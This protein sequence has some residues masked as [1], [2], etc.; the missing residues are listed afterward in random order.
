MLVSE[1]RI[2]RP[3][4]PPR[5]TSPVRPRR[6]GASNLAL[7]E[8]MD[9]EADQA[10]DDGNLFEAT[11]SFAEFSERLGASE[12]PELLEAAVAY[13]ACVEGKPNAPR[14]HILRIVIGLRP[15]LQDNREDLLRSFGTLLREGRLERA[16]GGHF[17][18]QN[19]APYM[20][21]GRALGN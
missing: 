7:S 6:V 1:Q 12:L 2:D 4:P 19:D 17:A 8:D 18:L 15:E 3:A 20:V 9:H 14:P 11:T 16:E 13:A 10:D 21:A 5:S